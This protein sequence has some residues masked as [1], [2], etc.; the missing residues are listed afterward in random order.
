[1]HDISAVD[2]GGGLKRRQAS[3][4]KLQFISDLENT[5][6]QNIHSIQII[7]SMTFGKIVYSNCFI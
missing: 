1:M 6:A 5:H 4:L 3:K 7:L 2:Y